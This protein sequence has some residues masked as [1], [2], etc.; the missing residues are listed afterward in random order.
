MRNLLAVVRFLVVGISVLMVSLPNTQAQFPCR[1]P[2]GM[3]GLCVPYRQCTF[4]VNVLTRYGSDLPIRVLDFLKKMTCN[5]PTNSQVKH[6]CCN[7]DDIQIT[8]DT[9]STTT[10]T[11]PSTTRQPITWPR[12]NN[13]AN[14]NQLLDRGGTLGQRGMEILSGIMCGDASGVRVAFGN[15]TKLFQYPWMALLRYNDA[16]GPFRCAGTLITDRHIL[17]AA[18]CVRVRG[19]TQIS[20]VRLGEHDIDKDPDCEQNAPELFCSPPPEDYQVANI[21][22]HPDY[23]YTRRLNDIAIIKLTE[24]VQFKKH[25]KPICL[26]ITPTSKQQI[27]TFEEFIIA[28]W[29]TTELGSRSTQLL[30]AVLP[31]VSRSTCSKAIQRTTITENHLCAGGDTQ[32][33]DACTGDSGG[34]LFQAALY[35]NGIT[36][37]VQYGIVSFGV[38][39]CNKPVASPSIY[40]NLIQLT[41]WIL[42][43]LS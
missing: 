33:S 34:P 28:G 1:T 31:V 36:R 13:N 21:I 24:K 43:N 10:T 4:V 32:M 12:P 17:T 7:L 23:S 5:G 18:H 22:V 37:F 35:G 2:F 20:G 38:K 27:E 3:A 11:T 8:G 39:E 40:A 41:P 6:F 19:G 30:Q 16:N 14:S 29:G 26:P 15:A 25:I 9:S 42:E